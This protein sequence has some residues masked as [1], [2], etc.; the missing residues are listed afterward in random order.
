MSNDSDNPKNPNIIFSKIDSPLQA[1][2]V[3]HG[4]TSNFLWSWAVLQR[5]LQNEKPFV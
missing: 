1:A 3:S 5:F 4:I 2:C